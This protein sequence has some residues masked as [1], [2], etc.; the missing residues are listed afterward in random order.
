M[1]AAH[2]GE[3]KRIVVLGAGFAGFSA[4]LE[5]ERTV[6]RDPGVEVLLIAP[7]NVAEVTLMFSSFSS[8]ALT[9]Q[10]MVVSHG[11]FMQ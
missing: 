6:A 1:K 10:S 8:N 2:L 3:P 4:A 7:Q 9:G 11:W 5:L